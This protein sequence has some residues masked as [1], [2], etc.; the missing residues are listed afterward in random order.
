MIDAT[1]SGQDEG[2]CCAQEAVLSREQPAFPDCRGSSPLLSVGA[3]YQVEPH[4]I[5]F[6]KLFSTRALSTQDASDDLPELED[7]SDGE[8]DEIF[9][10]RWL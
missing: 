1:H 4:N 2:I 3:T 8:D 9:V 6:N 10:D 7:E 5:G